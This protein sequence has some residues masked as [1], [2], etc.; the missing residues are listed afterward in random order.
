[1]A[2]RKTLMKKLHERLTQSHVF[3]LKTCLQERQCSCLFDRSPNSS[4]QIYDDSSCFLKRALGNSARDHENLTMSYFFQQ[5]ERIQERSTL[6]LFACS[7][8]T[9]VQIRELQIRE[10]SSY[11]NFWKRSSN[12]AWDEKRQSC[13]PHSIAK[14]YNLEQLDGLLVL[15]R[16]ALQLLLSQYLES[17]DR[18]HM[19]LADCF[20]Q[21]YSSLCYPGKGQCLAQNAILATFN[22]SVHGQ[23]S[24]NA[25]DP[26]AKTDILDLKHADPFAD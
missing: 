24:P 15:H 3:Q 21:D 10:D 23:L 12:D 2:R 16:R 6:S 19:A 20:V 17:H 14:S 9:G 11:N 25:T 13:L 7:P 26:C 5:M 18:E 1:M 8:N 22:P 4:V